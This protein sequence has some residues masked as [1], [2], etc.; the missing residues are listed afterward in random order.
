MVKQSAPASPS[1]P[2][3]RPTFATPRARWYYGY[4]LVV[5]GLIANFVA[6]GTDTLISGVFLVPMT[7]ELG[8]TRSE[9]TYAPTVGRFVMSFVG[10]FLGAYLDRWGGRR[11]MFIGSTLL[12][13]AL[14]S[15]SEVTTLWQ[16]ILIRGVLSAAGAGLLGSLV[17]NVMLSKWFVER[18]GRVIAVAAMGASFAGVILPPISNILIETWGWR[19]AWRIIAIAAVVLVYPLASLVRRQPEDRGLNPDG[20]S[21]EEVRHG[22]GAAAARD[23]AESFTRGEAVRTRALYTIVLSFGLGGVGTGTMLLHT[24]PLLEDSGFSSGTAVMM[25]SIM[26]TPSFASK[27]LWGWLIDRYPANKLSSLS[28]TL[29]C[30]GVVLLFI[31]LKSEMFAPLVMSYLL[32]GL[33]FGGQVPLQETI[34]ASYFG[35]RYLGSVRGVAMPLSLFLGAGGPLA[36]A[37]YFDA[38]GNY[39]G[40]L[41]AIA[42]FWALAAVLIL[43]M[44]KPTRRSAPRDPLAVPLVELPSI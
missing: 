28:F 9:Y 4:W 19:T 34:W 22:A 3:T 21:N 14:F 7:D 35:R 29:S 44:K 5:A 26:L 8:W 10:F 33:G 24:V 31:S 16:W 27:P 15:L 25:S 43:S 6:T 17:V 23:L 39:D 20:R 40:A 11:F 41:I 2:P 18:R 38:V 1:T 32:M 13:V 12:A 37:A 42:L 30:V 36:I